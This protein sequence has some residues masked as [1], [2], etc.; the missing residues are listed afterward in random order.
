MAVYSVEKSLNH[1]RLNKK[2]VPL[3]LK[4]NVLRMLMDII[5]GFNLI[6]MSI[7]RYL[8]TFAGNVKALPLK[9]VFLR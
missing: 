4:N 3:W 5:R 1:F 2:A 9:N 7:L 6:F 8:K